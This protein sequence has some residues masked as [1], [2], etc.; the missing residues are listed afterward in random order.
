MIIEGLTRGLSRARANTTVT[1]LTVSNE[2]AG[3]LS[4][5]IELV[6]GQFATYQGLYETQPWVQATVN[7]LA[8]G[9]SRLPLPIYVNGGADG[10]RTRV[11]EGPL[12][13]LLR[14]PWTTRE[15]GAIQDGNTVLLVQ[16]LVTNMLVAGF[17]IFVMGY[18]DGEGRRRAFPVSLMPSSPWAWWPVFEHGRLAYWN[19]AGAGG[20]TPFLPSEVWIVAPWGMGPGGM[21]K[22]PLAALRSTLM[23]EDAIQR[24]VIQRFEK[25]SRPIGFI[26]V[27]VE[28]TPEAMKARREQLNEV[29]AGVDNF[30]RMGLLDND[31][32]FH[33][34]GQTFVE[35]ELISLRKLNREEVTSV[36]NVPQPSV[37]ILD[38]ATFSNVSE[39]H[40][41]EY[42][43]TYGPP[44]VLIEESFGTQVIDREPAFKGMYVEFNF[45][46][47][48][49]GDPMKELDILT[50]AA[51]GPVL[52]LNEARATQNLP[53]L[54]GGDEVRE[55]QNMAVGGQSGPG[56][57][58]EGRSP[59]A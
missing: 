11:R 48:L 57:G 51:G 59:G 13:E 14:R 55:P 33:S 46:E 10:E 43:D 53:P 31:A 3:S 22:S 32:E 16:S 21:P 8:R 44:A 25:G 28:L 39:Q 15:G 20:N 38:R 12:F 36:L 2:L 45:K 6:G 9:L 47:V 37:G 58:T 34:M 24:A 30:Y 19:H 49:R 50:R 7:R 42:M 56:N 1:N 29:Y 35:S 26:S 41:M 23:A 40:L 5:S 4:R 52:T 54:E 18:V 17:S 27:K